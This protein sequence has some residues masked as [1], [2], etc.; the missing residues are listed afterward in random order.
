M[1]ILIT[2]GIFPPDIGGPATY[3][4]QLSSDLVSRGHDVVV[5]TLGEIDSRESING[6]SVIKVGRNRNLLSRML[7]TL[8]ITYSELRKSDAVF[9]NGLFLETGIALTLSFKNRVSV[10]KIVGDPLWER[11]RNRDKSALPF[12]EF[13][14]MKSSKSDS[15]LRF[16]YNN[17]WS[18]FTYRIAPSVELCEFIQ[19]QLPSK[20]VKYIPNGIDIPQ[21]PTS[22]RDND[23]ICVSRLVSWKN[24]DLA[25]RAAS[26]LGVSLVVIGDGPERNNL[27]GLAKSLKAD[28]FFL[29]QL[30]SEDV[31]FW[32]N[33][34][35][36]FL[37]LSDYEGLSFA[38]LEAMSRGLVPIVSKNQ[39]NISVVKP[40]INGLVVDIDLADVVKA[41]STLIGGDKFSQNLSCSAQQHV[42]NNFDGSIQRDKAIHLL[43]GD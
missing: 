12:N 28:A 4:P 37:L 29:G 15:L 17:A 18:K 14:Q 26:H 27:E 39:G 19:D 5:V 22:H 23:L 30:R 34:S 42:K 36:Y 3:I 21:I 41:I 35:K 24:I 2:S 40:D 11:A 38:L 8:L 10:A 20:S 1:K 25:I 33:R 16:A 43:V 9:S 32:L 7:K 31:A 6:Y 13:L